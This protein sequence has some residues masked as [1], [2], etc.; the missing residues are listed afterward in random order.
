MDRDAYR[1]RLAATTDDPADLFEHF[2]ERSVA[3][4]THHV[5]TAARHGVERGTVVVEDADVVVRGYPSIPRILVLEPGIESFF[6]GTETV[7]VEEKLDGFNVRIAAVGGEPLAFTRSGYVCPYTT[8]R[9]RAL[10]DLEPFFERH[11][12]TVLCAEL[13]GPET[14]YTT[15]D[16]AGVDSHDVRVFDVRDGES[17]EPMPVADRRA[18]CRAFDFGQ[19]RC[20]GRAAPSEAV[21]IAAAAIA[22]L[23]AAGREGVV[24]KSADGESMVKYTTA[25]QHRE[26]LAYAFSLPFECGRDFV[27]SRIVREAFRAAEFAES[28]DR[29][30]ERAHGLGEAILLPMVATIRAVAADEP[31]GQ[32]HTVRGDPDALEALFDHLREQSLTIE[33]EADRREDGDRVVAFRKVA[34]SSRDRIRHYLDGGTRDE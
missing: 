19:P 26:E 16:Y 14:P 5:L 12:E 29:L 15:T 25:S 10:L 20:F 24:L 27:F 2:E 30:R 23:D 7:V 18:L 17:G 11:P 3:G 13:I 6:A 34:D 33:I 28:D 8:A 9:A 22:D 31:I 32:R 21:E 4:R 1:E